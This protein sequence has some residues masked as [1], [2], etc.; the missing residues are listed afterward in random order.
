VYDFDDFQEDDIGPHPQGAVSGANDDLANPNT[1]L[2]LPGSGPSCHRPGFDDS[3]NRNSS[4]PAL[5]EDVRAT[6]KRQLQSGRMLGHTTIE[7]FLGILLPEAS[8]QQFSPKNLVSL[9]NIDEWDPGRAR[10]EYGL[11]PVVFPFCLGPL[12]HW[13]AF[14]FD[15]RN[16]S[17][18]IFNSARPLT[19]NIEPAIN[20]IARRLQEAMH[21]E[22]SSGMYRREDS[23]W[24][25]QQVEG[26]N[27]CGVMALVYCL[28]VAV[29]NQLSATTINT[30]IWRTLLLAHI[31]CDCKE[32]AHRLVNDFDPEAANKTYSLV[33]MATFLT[34]ITKRSKT[35]ATLINDT[36]NVQALAES[37]HKAAKVRHELNS[38]TRTCIEA[39]IKRLTTS[40]ADARDYETCLDMSGKIDLVQ[41]VQPAVVAYVSLLEKCQTSLGSTS[42]QLVRSKRVVKG[43]ARL[44]EMSQRVLENLVEIQEELH[45]MVEQWKV[46]MAREMGGAQMMMG[47]RKNSSREGRMLGV[48]R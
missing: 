10:R 2:Q 37:L 48:R 42:A 44:V 33:D 22:H 15:P 32:L 28:E 40:L 4:P 19:S 11:E 25:A 29:E 35:L 39:Q 45:G 34:D 7:H 26:S 41:G 14:K 9:D 6:M 47:S 24:I 1:W 23:G 12:K 27:D 46:E 16:R 8:I 3:S 36:E 30:S 20:T 38:A 5:Q 18:C 43:T 17:Y 13:I 31:G 21:L